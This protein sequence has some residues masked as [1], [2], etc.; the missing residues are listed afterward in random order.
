[1]WDSTPGN[2]GRRLKD[3]R[4]CFVITNYSKAIKSPTIVLTE[5]KTNSL[6]VFY[7]TLSNIIRGTLN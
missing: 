3:E 6:V 1:M 5:R 2:E 4:A 7:R